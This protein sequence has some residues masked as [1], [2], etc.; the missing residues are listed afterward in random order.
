[1]LVPLVNVVI[2]IMIS[3]NLSKRFGFGTGMTLLLVF[4]PFVGFPI[5]GFGSCRYQLLPR[6]P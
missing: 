4:L 1:M 2:T 3:H 6:N 5:L